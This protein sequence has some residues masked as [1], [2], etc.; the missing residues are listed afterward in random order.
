MYQEVLLSLNPLHVL[1]VAIVGFALGAV[2]YSPLLFVKAWMEEMNITEESMKAA[3][4]GV[5]RMVSALLLTL[6]ST[7]VLAALAADH[8][9]HGIVHGAELGVL[10]G[11]GLIASRQAVS[12]LFSRTSLRLFLIVA[13]HDIVLCTVQ[14]AILACWS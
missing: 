6:V 2:W 5:G 12:A 11:G 9:S 10:V 1:V 7:A 4:G 14:G 13:G 3:G 8:R